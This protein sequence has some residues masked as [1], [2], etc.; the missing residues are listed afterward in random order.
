VSTGELLLILT[1]FGA[2]SAYLGSQRQQV[3]WLLIAMSALVVELH[4][5][6]CFWV[7][8][9]EVPRLAS[10]YAVQLAGLMWL[11]GWLRSRVERPEVKR[12]LY[13]QQWL[14]AVLAIGTWIWHASQGLVSLVGHA[15]LPWHIGP[16]EAVMAIVAPLLLI[17]FGIAQARLT[18]RAVWVYG[19]AVLSGMLG[20][21]IRLSWL[22]L[23]P[24]Q[25]WDT[26]A[27]I[28]SAYALFALQRLTQ[29]RPMLHLVMVLP[30]LALATVP[31]QLNSPHVSGVLYI[32]A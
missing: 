18:R 13:G 2:V 12:A 29:S 16:V 9:D 31:F 3:G 20:L 30:L 25:V 19:V 21:Y 10:V 6:W 4:T 7:P 5:V 8:V 32:W 23:A 14:L 27:L 17:A 1:A 11:A 24:M 15:T 22:G 28:G 26:A